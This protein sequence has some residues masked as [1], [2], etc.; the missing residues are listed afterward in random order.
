MSVTHQ[1]VPCCQHVVMVSWLFF[2]FAELF[3]FGCCSLV[4]EMIYV[5]RYLPYFRQWLITHPLLLLLLFQPFVY[6][7]FAQRWAPC[8]SPP[9]LVCFQSSH[10]LCCVLVFSLLF[11]FFFPGVSL[12]RGLG[13]F[14]PGVA[15][16][17]PC[18]AWCSPVW[19]AKCLPSRFGARIWWWQQP[20]C[21]LSVT[22]CGEARGSRCQ[23]F[24]S[25]WCFI[26]TKYGSRISARFLIHGAHA[27][28]FCALVAILDPLHIFL[29]IRNSNF[30]VWHI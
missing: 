29:R 5:D 9:S 22:W 23:D 27:V 10:P 3:D 28:W 2:N 14:I 19:L 7:R 6:W 16:G 18:D 30:S 17:M 25:P 20:S 26:S 1:L 4:L 13:W 24:D 21:F 15:V 11:S 12:P 8:L